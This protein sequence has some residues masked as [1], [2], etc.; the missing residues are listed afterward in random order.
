MNT[1]DSFS[2]AYDSL[3]SKI[4]KHPSI[5]GQ[6]KNLLLMA[7]KNEQEIVKIVAGQFKLDIQFLKVFINL[8]NEQLKPKSDAEHTKYDKMLYREFKRLKK[9]ELIH[10]SSVAY[11]PRNLV[12]VS[13]NP[14]HNALLSKSYSKLDR[15]DKA[16][17]TYEEHCNLERV[18]AN[19]L[20]QI[21]VYLRLFHIIPF[22][23]SVLEK[24]CWKDLVF[25]PSGMVVLVIY[26]ESFLASGV[27][28]KG[29]KPYK[30]VLLDEFVSG[31][32]EKVRSSISNTDETVFKNIGNYENNMDANRS[33][34]SIHDISIA[35][36]RQLTKIRYMYLN[37][38]FTLTLRTGTVTPVQLSLADIQAMFPG[39]VSQEL[40]KDEIKRIQSALA[41]PA[42]LDPEDEMDWQVITFDIYELDELITLLRYK[43]NMPPKELVENALFELRQALKFNDSPHLE[44]IY[45]YLIYLI[46]LTQRRRIRLSTAKNYIWLLNKHL[47][48]MIE[49]FYTIKEHE[50]F[51]I[52]NRLDNREYKHTSINKIKAQINRF[53]KYFSKKGIT[54]DIAGAFYPKSLV[55]RHEIDSILYGLEENYKTW[56]LIVKL[57][58]HHKLYMTQLKVIVLLGFY[59]GLRLREV[60]S[61][62][63]KDIYLYGDELHLDINSKGIKK[64]GFKLKTS[65]SKRRIDVVIKN[66]QHLKIMTEFLEMRSNL[67]K[68]SNF[69]FLELS[70]YNGFL[71]KSINVSSFEYINE[72]IQSVTKRYCTYHS[73]RH[74]FATYQCQRFFPNGSSYP[75]ELLE[76]SDKIGHRTP[77]T[78]VQS[79]VHGGV[80]FLEEIQHSALVSC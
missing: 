16:I 12:L 10:K 24:V 72:I 9:F 69:L 77:D 3:R 39:T 68:K 55:F 33:K 66:P 32:F 21:Y 20:Q 76:L 50:V 23:L 27:E 26:E 73:L 36:L 53:F 57:G 19:V 52:S 25:T 17:A 61:M 13:I 78:T 48:G 67:D 22:T 35:E 37:S 15:L 62:L 1:T 70:E 54:I 42:P 51:R 29:P 65:S 60:S 7:L 49:D 45:E 34:S 8:A 46:D 80:L 4:T 56:K 64:T 71:N 47:F 44:M 75:Y 63:L 18:D 74:S 11:M 28:A 2:I 38:P 6:F 5:S 14:N 40:M 59:C 41:R 58:K 79:Y 31:L 30:T 43:D